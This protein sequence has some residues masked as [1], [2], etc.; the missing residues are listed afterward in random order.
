MFGCR[1]KKNSTKMVSDPST[2]LIYPLLVG[3]ELM[4]SLGQ[5]SHFPLHLPL[6]SLH[7]FLLSLHYRIEIFYFDL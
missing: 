4:G 5:Q 3:L 6:K 2:V 1:P 7:N